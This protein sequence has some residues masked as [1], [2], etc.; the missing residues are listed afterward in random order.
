MA[1]RPGWRKVLDIM[2]RARRAGDNYIVMSDKKKQVFDLLFYSHFL[3]IRLML[4]YVSRWRWR[5]IKECSAGQ[6]RVVSFQ[7]HG[8][9]KE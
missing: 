7:Y 1:M 8:A 4:L 3:N 2:D 6:Y 5:L 9:N